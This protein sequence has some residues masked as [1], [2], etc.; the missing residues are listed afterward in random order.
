M[1]RIFL[2][3]SLVAFATTFAWAEESVTDDVPD[4]VG[5]LPSIAEVERSWTPVLLPTQAMPWP[6]PMP[7]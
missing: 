4:S 2:L 3:P 5:G 1:K 6:W 7:P